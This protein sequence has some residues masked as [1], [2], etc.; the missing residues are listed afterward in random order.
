V[1][2]FAGSDDA[3]PEKGELCHE[4]RSR[5]IQDPDRPQSL[6]ELRCRLNRRLSDFRDGWKRCDKPLCRRSKHCCGKGPDFTCTD[7]G[8][9]RRT[10]SPEERA[11]AISDLYKEV[12][13]RCAERPAGGELPQK[14]MPQQLRDEP[15]AVTRRRRRRKSAQTVAPA[16]QV[17][18]DEPQTTVVEETQLA[19]ESMERIDRARNDDGASQP[20]EQ[21]KA[22]ERRPRI[23]QL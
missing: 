11:K 6:D 9:P 14:E 12:K 8:R 7:D 15:R 20:A 10:R 23:S 2:L 19:P 1:K 4:T 16:P 21:D 22:R 17:D 5:R 13:R 18:R 3:W